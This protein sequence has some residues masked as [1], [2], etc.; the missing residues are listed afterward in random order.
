M[1][2]TSRR[3]GVTRLVKGMLAGL[4][5]IALLTAATG[6]AGATEYTFSS[7]LPGVKFRADV[8][9]AADLQ[10]KHIVR[11]KTDISC[12]SAALATIL[13]YYYGDPVS[14]DEILKEMLNGRSPEQVRQ[15]NGFS[16]LEVKSA[17]EKLGYVA[18]GL[19]GSAEAL[20]YLRVPAIVLVN[21]NRFPHFVAVRGIVD[22]IVV[23][24]DPALGN[25]VM[26]L[27]EFQS[28][29]NGVLLAIEGNGKKPLAGTS[30]KQYLPPTAP[31]VG[32]LTRFL[33]IGLRDYA[34]D[35]KEF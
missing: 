26:T 1:P 13:Q 28:R 29:W 30:P 31:S 33:T 16:L 5:L 9:S 12:G 14:E 27:N 3:E 21:S 35:G 8:E 2:M 10:F 20:R 4:A 18:R 11:Q 22:D 25:V 34:F 23:L 6:A 15:G 32:S 24:A 17:A 19:K 7:G